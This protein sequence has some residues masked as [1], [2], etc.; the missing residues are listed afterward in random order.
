MLL[1]LKKRDRG[2]ERTED[3]STSEKTTKAKQKNKNKSYM[4]IPTPC[5]PTHTLI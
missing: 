4:V 3:K 5:S 2:H 1:S